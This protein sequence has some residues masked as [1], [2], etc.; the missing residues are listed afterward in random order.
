MSAQPATTYDN[1]GIL[2]RIRTK[3]T[4]RSPDMEGSGIIAGKEFKFVG[5][6]KVDRNGRKFLALKFTPAEESR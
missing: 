4:P 1:C 3:K 2:F 5:W 6:V